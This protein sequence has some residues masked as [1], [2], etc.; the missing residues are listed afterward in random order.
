MECWCNIEN[1][2]EYSAEEQYGSEYE[3]DTDN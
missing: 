3:D 2:D 1:D